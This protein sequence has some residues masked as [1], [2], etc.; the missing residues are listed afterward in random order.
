MRIARFGFMII[1]CSLMLVLCPLIPSK[2]DD[3]SLKLNESSLS[4]NP[5]DSFELKIC[6]ESF[7]G[8]DEWLIE[9]NRPLFNILK[10]EVIP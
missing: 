5:G 6:D 1:I 2:A 4:L 3:D 9:Y 10:R 7:D 8:L